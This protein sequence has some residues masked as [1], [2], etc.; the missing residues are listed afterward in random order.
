[1]SIFANLDLSP[2]IFGDGHIILTFTND[3]YFDYIHNM[4]INIK[5]IN[6]PW[7]LCVMCADIESYTKC[8][9]HNIAAIYVGTNHTDN[10]DLK[11]MATWNDANWNNVTFMKLTAMQQIM[12]HP[13]IK[14]VTFVDGDIHIYRDFVPYLLQLEKEYPTIE[15]FVQSDH[16]SANP[17]ERSHHICSGFYH[18]INTPRV[19]HIFNFGEEDL[20][21][22]THNADQ[23]HLQNKLIE[24]QIPTHQLS[25]HLFPNG[26]LFS[27]IPENPYIFHYNYMIGDEKRKNMMKMVHWY[28]STQKVFHR[29]TEV[30]Y[31]PFKKGLYLEEYFSKHN[32]IRENRYIDVFWTNIQIDPKFGGF[33][34]LVGSLLRETYPEEPGKKYFTVVQHDDGVM[35]KLPENTRV[36][37]AGGTGDVPIPLIYEDTSHKLESVQKMSFSEKTI[38]CSFLG[39]STHYV[40]AVMKATLTGK[41]GFH[42]QMDTWTN[43]I[44]ET[45]QLD[46]IELTVRSKFCL[47]P[48]GYGRTSFR[49]Y[50]AFQLGSIPIYIWD[51]IEWLPYKELIDYSKF[52]IS[53]HVSKIDTLEQTLRDI[54]ETAYA[55]M[56]AEYEK[57]KHYFTLEGMTQYILEKESAR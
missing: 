25:R 5:K 18:L 35:F 32:K 15:F 43:T 57:I 30:V 50:E 22:N 40:R 56:W 12:Q 52:C 11:K 4:D 24:Y 7:N 53:I 34:N 42:I 26:S 55:N 33:R 41:Q 28:L 23:Q 44:G 54:D 36:Y 29:P 3:G 38:L 14:R 46:F 31:P 10:S 13:E 51:D 21:K 45:K 49:F 1:M 37:A 20:A 16:M 9:V 48:R 47:A 8:Q 17:N 19:R 39:S 2:F 27:N 6:I